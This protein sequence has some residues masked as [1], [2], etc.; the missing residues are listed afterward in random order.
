MRNPLLGWCALLALLASPAF[1]KPPGPGVFCQQY[2]TSP[3]CAGGQPACTMCHVAAPQ[4]NVYGTALEAL[5]APGAPRPL[6]DTDFAMALPAALTSLDTQDS[7]G[8]GVTNLTEITRG[9]LPGDPRSYPVDLPCAGANNP[10]FKVCQ[11]DFNYVYRKLELDFCGASPTYAQMQQFKALATDDL[12]RTY[13]DSELDR[14]LATDFWRGKNGILWRMAHPKVRP[15]GSL[16]G[17]PEDQGQIPLADYY[18]DY[19]LFTWAHTDDHDVRDVLTANFYVQRSG[20]NPTV[21]TQ[22]QTLPL[23]AV[24]AAHRAGNMTSAWTLVYFV[25]FTA[26]PR[27]AAAQMY[28]AYLG[29]DIA[30]QEGLYSVPNEPRDY[31]SKGVTAQACAACHATLDPLSYPFRNYNGLTGGQNKFAQYT[32]NRIE[33]YFSGQAPSITQ[34]PESGAIFGQSVTSL[35][36]WATVAANSDAF[37]VATATDYWKLLIGHP[38]RP[39]ENTE[40]VATWRALKTTHNYRVKGLLHDLIRTEAYGAP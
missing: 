25:M 13:L 4:R 24:D 6:S 21:Y 10:Q 34:I 7:D 32:P 36:Q 23:Q 26:L 18:D 3:F 2:P 30:K 39:E 1:A 8:D 37:V 14:C 28:R 12:R 11:Y 15:V 17:G 40:F 38:P 31:D 9:T 5:I 19:A 29:Y 27:N 35:Q 20:T 16:K 22:V 33:T